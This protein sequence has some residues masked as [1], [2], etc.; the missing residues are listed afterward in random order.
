MRLFLF[1]FLLFIMLGAACKRMNTPQDDKTNPTG[2][3][4]G[5]AAARPEL[6]DQDP[7]A[8]GQVKVLM[9]V[10]KVLP[11]LDKSD[12]GPCAQ[13]PCRAEVL[14]ER[15]LGYGPAFTASLEEG[16]RLEV[17]FPMTLQAAPDRP[18]VTVGKKI[19]GKLGQP[20]MGGT[21][22]TMHQFTMRP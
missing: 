16:Q 17:Y 20:A 5:A 11:V 9:Q 6:P 7:I 19:E 14:V 8:P 10:V 2:K 15:I 1:C 18:A 4:L 3:R 13:S 12:A 22:F 21:V